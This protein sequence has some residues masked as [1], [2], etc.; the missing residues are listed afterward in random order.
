MK[1]A[2]PIDC[3]ACKKRGKTWAGTN[4][5]C[6]LESWENNWRCATLDAL[7]GIFYWHLEEVPLQ[8]VNVNIYE[9]QSVGTLFIADIEINNVDSDFPLMLYISWYKRRGRVENC[10]LLFDT[11]EPRH[12]TEKELDNII[13]HFHKQ[14]K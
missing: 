14:I 3:V 8:N 6:F 1:K 12:P 9:D 13:K 10:Y 4:A 11:K 7:R 2:K 5:T